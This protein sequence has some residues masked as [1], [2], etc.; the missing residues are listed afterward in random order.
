MCT[1]V[2]GGSDNAAPV[3]LL[4]C[5]PMLLLLLLLLPLPPHR[6]HTPSYPAIDPQGLGNNIATNALGRGDL[7]TELST[8]LQ[9]QDTLLERKTQGFIQF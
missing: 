1:V 3:F 7:Q 6:R 2:S 4:H 5:V 9:R 8:D